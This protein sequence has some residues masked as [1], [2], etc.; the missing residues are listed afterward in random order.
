MADEILRDEAD[1]TERGVDRVTEDPSAPLVD[2]ASRSSPSASSRARASS[3]S[4]RS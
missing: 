4:R 1:V 2:A 3:R